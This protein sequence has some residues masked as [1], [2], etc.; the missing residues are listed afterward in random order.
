VKR[1]GLVLGFCAT[2]VLA[3]GIY[4]SLSNYRPQDQNQIWNSSL[5]ISDGATMIISGVVLALLAALTWWFGHREDRR[6]SKPPGRAH[7]SAEGPPAPR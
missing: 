5:T 4:Q 7:A 2:A 1:I 3:D 6:R